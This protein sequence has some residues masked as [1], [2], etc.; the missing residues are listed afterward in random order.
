MER[1]RV[2]RVPLL[3]QAHAEAL[4]LHAGEVGGVI[5]C[6]TKG[7][8]PDFD[9]VGAKDASAGIRDGIEVEPSAVLKALFVLVKDDIDESRR[10]L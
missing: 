10:R 7:I 1:D 5:D 2:R 9:D 3:R 6:G 4:C 8:E